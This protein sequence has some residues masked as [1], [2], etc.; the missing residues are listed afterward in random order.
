MNKPIAIKHLPRRAEPTDA[1]GQFLA[2][3]AKNAGEY[4]VILEVGA[5]VGI[6]T[7]WLASGNKNA[8]VYS[9]DAWELGDTPHSH[10]L[11]RDVYMLNIAYMGFDDRVIPVH[12]FS[13]EAAKSWFTPLDMLYIDGAHDY[14]NVRADILA[15]EP[16]VKPGGIL[17]LHDADQPDVERALQD[18]LWTSGRYSHW[19]R[20]DRILS[21]RKNS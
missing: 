15:W 3:L 7:C 19:S 12:A 11:Y 16:F 10:K 1:E 9:V 4:P 14:D 2:D 6:S 13:V 20:N 21:G 18:T 8:M 5:C 17:A